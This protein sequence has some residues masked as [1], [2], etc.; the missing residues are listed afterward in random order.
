MSA[1][2]VMRVIPISMQIPSAVAEIL[3]GIIIFFVLA[4]EFFTQYK[5]VLV[6]K[7]H[8]EAAK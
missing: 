3:Q 1:S 7:V 8:K 4:S 6:H 5:F 2:L